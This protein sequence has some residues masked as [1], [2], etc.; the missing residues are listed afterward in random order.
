MA[1]LRDGFVRLSFRCFMS[2]SKARDDWRNKPVYQRLRNISSNYAAVS[3][4]IDAGLEN[5]CGQYL[6]CQDRTSIRNRITD[7]VVATALQ[8]GMEDSNDAA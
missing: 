5:L 2:F 6:T 7:T 8:H 1:T 3:S 4:I